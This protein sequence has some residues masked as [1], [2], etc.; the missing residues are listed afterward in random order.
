MRHHDIERRLSAL[1]QGT[2]GQGDTLLPHVG[3][4][5]CFL[6]HRLRSV[7]MPRSICALVLSGSKVLSVGEDRLVA[8]EGD[9]FL[10]PA[11]FEVTIE[12]NP[13]PARGRYLALCL[14]L[15]AETLASVAA[16]TGLAAPAAPFSLRSLRVEQ[17]A[18]LL[19]SLAHLLDMAAACPANERL[20]ALCMEA[21]LLLVSERAHCFAALWRAEEA[22]RARCARLV[23][24]DPAKAWTS[25]GVAG[26]LGVSERTL[27]RNLLREGSSL[28]QVLQGVRLNAALALL[29]SGGA[30]VAEAALRCGY[31]SPSRFAALFRERFGVKPS[32]I[33][34]FKAGTER[35]LAVSD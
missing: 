16:R 3:M 1:V 4:V 11:Q 25:S 13:D 7:S 27:R 33:G 2:P 5:S 20:L 31:E 24:M 14:T 23:S 35:N 9:M 32:D 12:N 10:L 34:R 26:R 17:D 28:R 22:W 19:A 21:F 15:D 30:G 18:P 29:Q 8:S 6:R